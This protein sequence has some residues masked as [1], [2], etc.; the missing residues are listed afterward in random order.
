VAFPSTECISPKSQN[1]QVLAL[2]TYIVASSLD[3]RIS[4]LVFL[5]KRPLKFPK[6][7]SASFYDYSGF[8]P[9]AS[10]NYKCRYDKNKIVGCELYDSCFQMSST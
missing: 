6:A 2:N 9:H 10:L 5:C 7:Q 1:F 3:M 8:F 4:F